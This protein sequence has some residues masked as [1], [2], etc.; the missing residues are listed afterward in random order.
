FP[1]EMPKPKGLDSPKRVDRRVQSA[2]HPANPDS[3]RGNILTLKIKINLVDYKRSQNKAIEAFEFH[4]WL[5]QQTFQGISDAGKRWCEVEEGTVPSCSPPLLTL[6]ISGADGLS[7]TIPWATLDCVLAV[8]MQAMSMVW[9]QYRFSG[10]RFWQL[11]TY[12]F[13]CRT[14]GRTSSDHSTLGFDFQTLPMFTLVRAERTQDDR[15]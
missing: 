12:S 10:N 2:W 3:T 15:I 4:F 11:G 14:L 8:P 7:P 1:Q 13:D 6:P 9:S 5:F